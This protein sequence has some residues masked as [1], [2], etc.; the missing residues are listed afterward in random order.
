M[1]LRKPKHVLDPDWTVVIKQ[2]LRARPIGI[3]SSYAKRTIS[4]Y[5]RENTALKKNENNR[6]QKQ[7]PIFFYKVVEGQIPAM[8]PHL[9][10]KYQKSRRQIRAKNL[11][12]V[13]LTI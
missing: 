3:L 7:R 5:S 4:E 12:I 10:V 1:V 2:P 11:T 13:Y 8:P 6:G 9:F